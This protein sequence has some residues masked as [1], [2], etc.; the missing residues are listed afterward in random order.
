MQKGF[1]VSNPRR[2]AWPA[3]AAAILF[4]ASTP[5]AKQLL[6]EGPTTASPFLLAGLL[7]LGSGIGLHLLKGWSLLKNPGRFTHALD[8]SFIFFKDCRASDIL[9]VPLTCEICGQW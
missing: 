8:A 7:Y 2:A 6:G 5:L 4:G 9:Y 3:L 1:D